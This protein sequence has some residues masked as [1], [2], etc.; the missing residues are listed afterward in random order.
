[1]PNFLRFWADHRG[2]QVHRLGVLT[3]EQKR[4]FY[5]GIDLFALPSR[6]DSFGLVL[7]E[8][9][10]NGLANLGYRAGGI[11]GVIS[12]EQDGLLVRCGDLAGLST[13][14]LRLSSDAGL[15]Q[16]LGAAGLERTWH[17]FAWPEK[18]ELVRRVYE[19][20]ISEHIMDPS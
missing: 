1:M 12:H 11:A 4:A 5:A 8:A 9:W 7:L 16:R 20:A 6:S 17:E 15:R 10:V 18:F 13:A 19:E 2:G 14:L 3:E